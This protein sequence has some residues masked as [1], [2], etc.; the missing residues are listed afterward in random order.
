M[1]RIRRHG[2][3]FTYHKGDTV[4]VGKQQA[5]EWIMDGTAKDPFNQ[6]RDAVYSKEPE[7]FGVVVTRDSGSVQLQDKVFSDVEVTFMPEWEG[8]L[9]YKYTVLW[10]G[11][12]KPRSKYLNYGWTLISEE[13]EMAA[14]LI[15]LDRILEHV[16]D[17]RDRR[18]TMRVFDDL[19]IP[20]YST[21][22]IW[23]KANDTTRE[24]ATTYA[25]LLA[26]NVN[27][28]H[29]FARTW[30]EYKPLLYTMPMDWLT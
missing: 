15:S 11:N 30:Y 18:D 2:K 25:S 13:W 10:N 20:A 28:S 12:G 4:E 27:P 29:A 22:V 8:E 9:P 21:K 19:R 1:V 3:Q 7:N 17:D 24:F 16:G 6:V 23:F 26:K 5:L 14:G